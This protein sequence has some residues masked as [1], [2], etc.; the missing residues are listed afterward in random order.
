M[1]FI[2]LTA[3]FQTETYELDEFRMDK[4]KESSHNG[5][6]VIISGLRGMSAEI[7]IYDFA[8]DKL[9]RFKDD[10]IKLITASVTATNDY[11][12]TVGAFGTPILYH[13]SMEAELLSQE[14]LDLLENWP[15]ECFVLAISADEAG[16][17]WLT[18]SSR[19]RRTNIL[20]KL[21]KG[22]NGK[23][24][25][26]HIV[27]TRIN[28]DFVSNWYAVGPTLHHLTLETGSIIVYD[29]VTLEE[30]GIANPGYDPVENARSRR[31]FRT[32]LTNP[33]VFGDTVFLAYN[34]ISDDETEFIT[35]EIDGSYQ[36]KPHDLQQ[37]GAHEGKKLLLDREHLELVLVE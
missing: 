8:E 7:Y 25:D 36:A 17:V 18:L 5:E 22:K 19:D 2:L 30:V 27:D 32:I 34:R 21:T 24:L 1:L 28:P 12:L 13:I 26:F 16:T 11:F 3:F 15:N 9:L 37:I 4:F 10:R 35:L 29:K 14:R 20:G 6:H 31:K 33:V 23:T